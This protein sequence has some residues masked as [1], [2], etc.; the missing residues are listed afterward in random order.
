MSE[1]NQIYP[2]KIYHFNIFLLIYWNNYEK[3]YIIFLKKKI[4]MLFMLWK[5]N[6]NYKK[7]K[8]NI[9]LRR[10]S[11]FYFCKV[12]HYAIAY[13]FLKKCMNTKRFTRIILNLKPISRSAKLF[14]SNNTRKMCI[15]TFSTKNYYLFK[16]RYIQ[17]IYF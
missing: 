15:S 2:F 9:Y 7:W 5:E 1:V 10:C 3:N 11:F 13:I 6:F 12:M 4:L 17:Y 14:L 8:E 16:C